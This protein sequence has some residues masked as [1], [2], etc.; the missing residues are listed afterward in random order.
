MS[1]RC[2]EVPHQAILLGKRIILENRQ[3]GNY[4]SVGEKSPLHSLTLW[5]G[6]WQGG[7]Q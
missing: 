4:A 2:L 7:R 6:D 5:D 1:G 3:A